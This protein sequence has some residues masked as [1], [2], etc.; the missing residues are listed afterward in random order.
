MDKTLKNFLLEKVDMYYET[1]TV[2][3]RLGI[4]ER[5]HLMGS[6]Y[7]RIQNARKMAETYC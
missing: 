7:C 6:W 1:C 2:E 3:L 5:M 4:K